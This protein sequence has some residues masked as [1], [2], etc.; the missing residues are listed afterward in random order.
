MCMVKPCGWPHHLISPKIFNTSRP[1]FTGRYRQE[2]DF[3]ALFE[4]S[5]FIY[6]I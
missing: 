5:P 2:C 4:V 1:T 3:N 6:G